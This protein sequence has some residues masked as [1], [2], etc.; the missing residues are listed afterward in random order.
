MKF[1]NEG[2]TCPNCKTPI[3]KNY[4]EDRGHKHSRQPTNQVLFRENTEIDRD[5]QID[6]DELRNP[7]TILHKLSRQTGPTTKLDTSNCLKVEGYLVRPLLSSSGPNHKFCLFS[8]SF[9]QEGSGFLKLR[10]WNSLARCT[11]LKNLLFAPCWMIF[12]ID[13]LPNLICQT[14]RTSPSMIRR[15]S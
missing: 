3:A 10:L 11:A 8:R 1:I 4:F 12:L 7:D 5:P 2:N 6:N 9:L 14:Y 15:M 13:L